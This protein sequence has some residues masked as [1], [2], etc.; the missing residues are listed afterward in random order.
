MRAQGSSRTPGYPDWLMSR[1]HTEERGLVRV[2]VRHRGCSNRRR[3]DTISTALRWTRT[4]GIPLVA[5]LLAAVLAGPAS[6]RPAASAK[7][8]PVRVRIAVVPTFGSL[9]VEVAL[10]KGFFARN[11]LKATVTGGP[12]I[13]AFPPAL[14]K[15]FDV[16]MSTPADFLTAAARGIHIEALS[17]MIRSTEK[18]PNTLLVTKD[19]SIKTAADLRGKRIGIVSLAGTNYLQMVYIAER[20]GI[21]RTDVTFVPTPFP[22]MADQLNAGRL[23]AAVLTIP[24]WTPLLASGYRAVFEPFIAAT[25]QTKPSVAF[26]STSREFVQAH[27]TAVAAFRR[28]MSQAIAWIKANDAAARQLLAAWLGLPAD[29]ATHAPLPLFDTTIAAADLQPW[30]KIVQKAGGIAKVPSPKTLVVPAKAG[31]PNKR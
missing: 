11:G 24:F 16:I 12:D 5:A 29:V 4:L 23:D 28:A 14:G 19:P 13:G 25:G 2:M 15:Q 21:P 20:S 9:P 30:V 17:G 6:A 7:L 31:R 8:K 27:P 18:E 22:T 1:R 10:Q 3:G 26:L